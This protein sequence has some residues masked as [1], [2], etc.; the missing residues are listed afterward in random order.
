[1]D[2]V[3]YFLKNR[4]IYSRKEQRKIIKKLQKKVII[5]PSSQQYPQV[6]FSDRQ[7]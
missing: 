1:M 4:K 3:L 5:S 2:E 7:N 6:P